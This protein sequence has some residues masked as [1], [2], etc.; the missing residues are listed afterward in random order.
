MYVVSNLSMRQ[1]H[2]KE[3]LI[4]FVVIEKCSYPSQK[5][6]GFLILYPKLMTLKPFIKMK[7]KKKTMHEIQM[8]CIEWLKTQSCV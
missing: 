1:I 6:N 7:K 4:K 8:V 2:T 3:L 5:K